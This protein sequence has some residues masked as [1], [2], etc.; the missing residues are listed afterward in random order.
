M[1]VTIIVEEDRVNVEGH[2]ETVDCSS[3]GDV[4]V[5]Q[6]YGT[7]GEVE[8]FN[9]PGATIKGNEAI[10]DFAPYQKYLDAWEVAAKAVPIA[11]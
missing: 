11:A 4:H 6:W 1:R 9:A 10:T 5:I 8:F 7:S 2:S 3:L